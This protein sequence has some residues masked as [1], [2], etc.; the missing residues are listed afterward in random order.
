MSA[1]SRVHWGRIV[2]A[3]FLSEVAVLALFFVLL[4]A[5]TLAGVPEVARPMSPL[6]YVDALVS[7]FG[8]VF[9]P[10]AVGR[11]A[12]RIPVHP[13]RRADRRGWY[14]SVRDDVGGHH[15]ITGAASAVR[16]CACSKGARRDS[17]GV[18]RRKAKARSSLMA[19]NALLVR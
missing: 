1:V 17:G 10:H 9:S 12:N 15:R 13:P 5:A 2:V 19:L 18:G 6:D 14:P 16:P 4:I 7:S 8:M 3:G 11:Q